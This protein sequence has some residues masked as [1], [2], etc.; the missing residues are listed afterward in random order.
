MYVMAIISLLLHHV[1]M[2]LN[3]TAFTFALIWLA[4]AEKLVY[5]VCNCQIT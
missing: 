3:L 5:A 1:G 4:T 2:Q